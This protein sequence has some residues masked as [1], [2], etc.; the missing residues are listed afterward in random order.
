MPT[1][2]NIPKSKGTPK[3]VKIADTI[4]VAAPLSLPKIPS[5]LDWLAG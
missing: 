5:R 4:D 2:F 1:D 3:R